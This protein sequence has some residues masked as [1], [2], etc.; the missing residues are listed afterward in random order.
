MTI[1]SKIIDY[2]CLKAKVTVQGIPK[3]AKPQTYIK[4]VCQKQQ[5]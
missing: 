1:D 2:S 5:I 4:I 3:V